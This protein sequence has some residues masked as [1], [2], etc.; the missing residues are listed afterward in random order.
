M[1][2][3][4][5]LKAYLPASNTSCIIWEEKERTFKERERERE[6]EKEKERENACSNI[7]FV[8]LPKKHTAM[9]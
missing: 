3:T 2:M 5:H 6:R 9:C 1:K 8:V 4:L 7:N